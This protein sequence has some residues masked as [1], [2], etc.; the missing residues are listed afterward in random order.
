MGVKYF[1][2]EGVAIRAEIVDNLMLGAHELS[3]MNNIS[4]AAG[5]E[6]RYS[7]FHLGGRNHG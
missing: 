6:F 4:I 2:H 7:G 1:W 3:T 5:V